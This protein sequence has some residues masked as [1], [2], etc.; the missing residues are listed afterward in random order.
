MLGRVQRRGY[1]LP[2]T[3][4]TL[5]R[6]AR[7]TAL[8][9]V[10]LVV[11]QRFGVLENFWAVVTAGIA[12]IGVG[13]IALWSVLSN[14]LCSLVLMITNPFRAGD[15]IELTAHQLRGRVANFNLIFTTLEDEE[16]ARVLFPNNLVFQSP[17][18]V[19]EAETS[20]ALNEQLYREGDAPDE[21]ARDERSV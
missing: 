15:R 11:L 21:P 3:V 1:L 6:I 19:W 2:H 10:A 12:L 18:R 4:I 9:I 7:W 16:G 17:V 13:F 8:A 20:V 5:R 14:V